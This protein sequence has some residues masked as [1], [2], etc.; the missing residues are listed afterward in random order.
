MGFLKAKIRLKNGSKVSVL[1]DTDTEINI[2]TQ[3]VMEDIGFTMQH[4]PK[5]ELVSYKGHNCLF[6]GL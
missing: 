2:M 3:E 5:L 1:L 4:D 6:L